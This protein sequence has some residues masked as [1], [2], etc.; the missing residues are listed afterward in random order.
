MLLRFGTFQAL[1]RTMHARHGSSF[2][3]YVVQQGIRLVEIE[4]CPLDFRFHMHKN[5]RNEWVTA[6]IG[7]KKPARAA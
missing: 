4:G 2:G 1:M 5:G 6:G 3:G 7:A